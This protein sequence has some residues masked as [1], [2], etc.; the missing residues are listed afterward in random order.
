VTICPATNPFGMTWS[1]EGI[2]FAQYGKGILRVSPNGGPPEPLIIAKNDKLEGPQ[3]PAWW[4][5]SP[6]YS[7][8]R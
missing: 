8:R 6:V 7:L 4:P 3:M 5:S 1:G 2:V